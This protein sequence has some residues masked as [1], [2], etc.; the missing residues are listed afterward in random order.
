[1]NMVHVMNMVLAC[2]E[3]C[4]SLCDSWRSDDDAWT[5]NQRTTAAFSSRVH[6][7]YKNYGVH[8][9]LNY[10]RLHAEELL[11]VVVSVRIRDN[12][13]DGYLQGYM[14]DIF[15]RMYM[16]SEWWNDDI[17]QGMNWTYEWTYKFC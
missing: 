2:V 7:N 6:G 17:K 4:G 9:K 14:I 13:L 5:T 15:S 3:F 16:T 8:T 1:M 11:H 10:W 12:M